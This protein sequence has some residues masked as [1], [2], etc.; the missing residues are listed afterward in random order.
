MLIKPWSHRAQ[1]TSASQALGLKVCTSTSNYT[2]FFFTLRTLTFIQHVFLK[3]CKLFRGFL[4]VWISPYCIS[5]FFWLHKSLPSSIWRVKFR[6]LTAGSFP[7]LSFLWF[8]SQG[9][10]TGCY[11]VY[12]HNSTVFQDLFRKQAT[13][14]C[15]QTTLSRHACLNLPWQDGPESRHFKIAQHFFFLWLKTEKHV[16]E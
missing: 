3:H 14:F 13:A 12:C 15:W 11:H 4:P 9:R 8:Q 10:D 1:S 6:T 2:V 7:F 5:H 16:R